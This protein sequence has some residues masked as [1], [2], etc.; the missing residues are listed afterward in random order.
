MSDKR[1]SAEEQRRRQA[2]RNKRIQEDNYDEHSTLGSFFNFSV[3]TAEVAAVG[4]ASSVLSYRSGLSPAIQRGFNFS[5][6]FLKKM[7]KS[8]VW[9]KELGDWTIRDFRKFKRSAKQNWEKTWQDAANDKIKFRNDKESTLAGT[10]RKMRTARES[11]YSRYMKKG[12]ENLTAAN[13]S[14]YLHRRQKEWN[15]NENE[16]LRFDNYIRTAVSTNSEAELRR[17]RKKLG[18]D[19]DFLFEAYAQ[20]IDEHIR[21]L[22]KKKIRDKYAERFKKLE[23]DIHEKEMDIDA[24]EKTFGTK[25]NESF[26]PKTG[27]NATVRD[28]LK[29]KDKIS[30]SKYTVKNKN[31]SFD[32]IDDLETALDYYR[33]KDAEEGIVLG[34]LSKEEYM[35]R[36]HEQRFLD[37][38]ADKRSLKKDHSGRIYD[39][40]DAQDLI[41]GVLKEFAGTT[42]GKIVKGRDF[43]TARD[44]PNVY[45][46]AKGSTDPILA[47]M[48]NKKANKGSHQLDSDMIYVMGKWYRADKDGLNLVEEMEGIETT[49]ASGKVGARKHLLRQIA[50]DVRYKDA[51]G[52]RK[53]FDIGMDRDE[54]SGD[55]LPNFN[56]NRSENKDYI[57]NIIDELI[58]P[59]REN[60]QRLQEKDNSDGWV[61]DF[62][63]RTDKLHDF[64]NT[65]TYSFNKTSAQKLSEKYTD[66]PIH[67]LLDELAHGDLDSMMSYLSKQD[68]DSLVLGQVSSIARKV[69]EDPDAVR[70]HISQKIPLRQENL[71]TDVLTG[72]SLF[73]TRPGNYTEDAEEYLR[74][75]LSKEAFAKIARENGDEVDY[76]KV[77]DTLKEID[78]DEQERINAIRLAELSYLED[79]AKL[80]TTVNLTSG[81]KWNQAYVLQNIASDVN[82]D[83]MAKQL[84]EDLE[85]IATENK[86]LFDKVY[87]EADEIG[88]PLQYNDYVVQRKTVSPLDLLKSI[89]DASKFKATAKQFGKQFVAGRDDLE[90]VSNV[91]YMPYFFLSRLSD[92]MNK[93]GLGLSKDSMGSTWDMAK[94]FAF[95]RILPAAFGATYLEWMDDTSEELTG[96]S[97]SGAMAQGVA[98][99]DIASRKVLDTLGMT[100][101]LKG[102]KAINP[103]MQYWGDHD[104]F[105]NADER[106]K[107]YE[108]GYTPVRK[109]AWWTFGGVNEAR[110]AEIE[111]WEPTFARR[112]QSDYKDKSLYDGYFDKWS[113]S[114]LP[115]PSNPFSPILGILD[116]YW[117][118]ERHKDDRPYELT[119]HMFADGTPW[120]AVLNPTIGE[121]IKPQKSLHT[122]LGF[123]YRNI[124]GVDPKALMYA[125]NQ[126]IKQKA[127]DLGHRN[128]IQVKGDDFAPVN[129]DMYDAPTPDTSVLSFQFSDGRYGS[130]DQGVYGTY[131]PGG[132]GA[133]EGAA[134][135]GGS[136]TGNEGGGISSF[137]GSGK[138]VETL[139]DDVGN[140]HIGFIAALDHKIF[141]GPAPMQST[142]LVNNNGKLGV[143][144]NKPE[145]TR[146]SFEDELKI[147]DL[148]DK[149]GGNF[150][151]DLANIAHKVNVRR[152]MASVNQSTKDKAKNGYSNPY[153]VDN[154]EVAIHGNKLKSYRP[155]QAM[156][157]LSDP[158]EVAQLI[159]QEKG[160]GVVESAA[161]SWRLLSGIYGY[162]LGEATG[163][164]V[165]DRRRIATGQDMTS[166][167][168]T[169]WDMNL[170]GLGGSAAEIARRLIP[171]YR[172][173]ARVNP[174]MNEMPDWLPERFRFGD[175]FAQ[176]KEGEMRLPGKGWES[177]NKLHSDQFG[178]YGA[179]DRMK[180]LADVAPFSPEYRMWRDIA[181]KTVTDPELVEEM[182]EIKDRVNQQSK[183]HDFYDYKVVGKGLEYKQV[184]VSEVL[185][186]GKFRSG[187]TIFK[188]AGVHLRA[189]AEESAQ[190]VL[191]RY[192]HAGETVT[193]AADSDESMQQN[194]DTQQTVN[195]AVFAGGEN[196]GQKMIENGD[197]SIRKGDTSSAA[198][199]ANY[200]PT[201][202]MIAWGSELIAHM[203]VPWLS[204][205]FL[206]VRSPLESYN[207]EQVYGTPYQSWEHPIDSFLLPALERAVHER[208]A[209][210]GAAGALYR[211]TDEMTGIAPGLK[212]L[213][214][215]AYLLN[216][217][218]AFIGAA[219]G[220]LASGEK[221]DRTM[222]W[223]RYGSEITSLLHVMSGGNSYA[224]ESLSAAN[225]GY[226]VARFLE[227]DSKGK[228]KYAAIGAAISAIYHGLKNPDGDWIPERTKDKWEMEDYFDRLTYLKY[229]GL[230]HAAAEKAKEEE[231]VDIEDVIQRRE[232]LM[233]KNRKGIAKYKSLKKQLQRNA[234]ES[235]QRTEMIQKLNAKIADLEGETMVLPG[236]EWTRTALL[237][238]QAADAT[239]FALDE[240][241][242]WS[243]IVTALPTNDREYFME[244]VKE[245]NEGKREQILKTV[246]PSLR[247]ALGL[248]W[249]EEV[250]EPES[251]EDFFSRHELPVA[252]WAG[253]APD[254]DL[255]DV[256]V[257]TIAN[258]AMNLSDFGFYDSQL[259]NDKVIDAPELNY[260]GTSL[261]H[262]EERIRENMKKVLQGA[263][264]K[265]VDISVQM[266][267]GDGGTTIYAA[268]KTMMGYREQ[269]KMVNNSL[270]MYS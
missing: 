91:T 197:A 198:I 227:K 115:T 212:K 48:S 110:G 121:L 35:Q 28:I 38:Y 3:R 77:I 167:S 172:R 173:N 229:T 68:E 147:Q 12:W 98:E 163:F 225:L 34:K 253:W 209:F 242:S 179:F 182:Q 136:G 192:V 64:L 258:E 194:N 189:N 1:L 168:R 120:G 67:E 94:A 153:D 211:L 51:S 75:L 97:M 203:D 23:A 99:F 2:A 108:E 52:L 49:F 251:N 73:D 188:I 186:Y 154:E 170:G 244:F 196:I 233:E 219:I 199:L 113:H 22:N 175:P 27:R 11:G 202:K 246:S 13:T 181:Q 16:L 232:E 262:N 5:A 40:S 266:G 15:L 221:A 116:P 63:D 231:D 24:M 37:L 224:D 47:A 102:E 114:L 205:Q 230:Y 104:D 43:A 150:F 9:E 210:T 176:I 241:S 191:N 103:I 57:P 122:F 215:A 248:A 76:T 217:R 8:S 111:Y 137:G 78:I 239:M 89:N 155:S 42:L 69:R 119:G 107:Y 26:G 31:Q 58:N 19:K 127:A 90:N 159:N 4:Y 50:G 143:I 152:I 245:R 263:G 208:T 117:L 164:G 261:S 160:A 236:G 207:A 213:G 96:M 267:P 131:S 190:E 132:Q 86:H 101:W 84:H 260:S 269:Q 249:G 74:N 252:N 169:F 17:A 30:A 255:K 157:F 32:A 92:E 130:I 161:V 134:V 151:G 20:K 259:R 141:G 54:F 62:L 146:I 124:N 56:F 36:S 79:V 29:R 243:Q 135:S 247:R 185:G 106:R 39:V 201:Q 222:R 82:P 183:K 200:S 25:R 145:H 45:Y 72:L 264:L 66:G 257:K 61:D 46:A 144:T 254:Y 133:G 14:R 129:V 85:D 238:K 187:N 165:D 223:A 138:R 125:A 156:D 195:V 226:E 174:L 41:D 44:L 237:Y 18:L 148:L 109:G 71:G 140:E 93:V 180:I 139:L 128:Y 184:V 220:K 21:S 53:F 234:R 10:L 228:G 149:G 70:R 204:D 250:E 118:E 126:Y 178:T 240:N 6:S 112:I 162:A 268:L 33:Q 80:G 206:R 158:D 218:G 55:I 105:Q 265:D 193:V 177:L 81:N 142:V 256:Q 270:I 235:S 83:K 100:D 87:D 216:D 65:L 166:F 95:K 171:D 7:K 123:D 60:F 214:L 59:T 88:N